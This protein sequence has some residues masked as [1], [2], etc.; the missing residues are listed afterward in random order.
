MQFHVR[1]AATVFAVLAM[2]GGAFV[3]TSDRSATATSAPSAEVPTPQQVLGFEPCAD[4]KLA[5]YEET[6]RY[7]RTLEAASR[8]R[9]QLV[10]LP[11][12]GRR[13]HPG[14]GDHHLRAEHAWAGLGR[15]KESRGRW[16]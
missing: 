13:A 1:S 2:A 3:A 10:D 11:I 8:N 5:T 16:R 15:Y 4:Y 14:D 12:N 7:F 6:I 9:M